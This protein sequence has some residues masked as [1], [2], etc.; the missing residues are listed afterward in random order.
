MV[1]TVSAVS[2][3]P[4]VADRAITE[5]PAPGHDKRQYQY[6]AGRRDHKQNE[7]MG[8]SVSSAFDGVSILSTR[9]FPSRAAA[10][11]TFL[12][13]CYP[14]MFGLPSLQKKA[15]TPLKFPCRPGFLC[16]N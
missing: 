2:L 3:P 5:T 9:V 7:R 8:Q 15:S 16:Y 4:L 10:T 14:P 6:D 1:N 12:L 13:I 11:A